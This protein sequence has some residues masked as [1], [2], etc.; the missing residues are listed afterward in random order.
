M[1]HSQPVWNG[2]AEYIFNAVARV[3]PR[4]HTKLCSIG[5]HKVLQAVCARP[6]QLLIVYTPH[7][8]NIRPIATGHTATWCTCQ[9]TK[10]K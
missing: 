8:S 10:P 4:V 9:S 5:N 1:V 6:C 7:N 2:V 3:S